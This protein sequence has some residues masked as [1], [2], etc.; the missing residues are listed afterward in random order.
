MAEIYGAPVPGG[1]R[2]VLLFRG[3]D[4]PRVIV[5][6]E[7]PTR[8]LLVSSGVDV[9]DVELVCGIGL[10]VTVLAGLAAFLLYRRVRHAP[11]GGSR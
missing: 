5:P 6:R 11:N 1:T 10:A 3:D 8:R 4:D 9:W 7:E 2:R